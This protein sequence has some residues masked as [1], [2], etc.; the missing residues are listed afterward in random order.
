[1]NRYPD[2]FVL[3]D[4][5]RALRREALAAIA[6]AAAIKWRTFVALLMEKASAAPAPNA[7]L[8][9]QGPTPTHP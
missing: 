2:P 7:P 1:M 6:C 4:K 8:P 5:A 3:H 9:C